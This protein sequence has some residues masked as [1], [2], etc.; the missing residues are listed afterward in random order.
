MTAKPM[1]FEAV[2][3][4]ADPWGF[5]SLWYEARKRDVA[6][7]ALPD[8]RYG[9]AFEAG[10]A[11]GMLTERLATRCDSLLA[12]DLVPRAVDRARERV[13]GHRHVRVATANLPADWPA[14]ARFDLIVLSELGYYFAPHAWR[15]TAA[16]AAAALTDAG[17]ILACHW[18]RPFAERT[19][20]TRH[21]H[22]AIARQPGLHRHVRHLE[23]DFLLEVWSRDARA[24][25]E[26]EAA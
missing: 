7:A 16:R 22:A 13:A 6:M 26:R 19:Q 18:L 20:S 25:R 5:E 15:E 2:F 11:T 8:P 10:C 3:Q 1:D 23:P 24:L 9:A 14:G 17:V 21:V 4:D 12:V